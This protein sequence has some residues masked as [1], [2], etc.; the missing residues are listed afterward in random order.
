MNFCPI[1]GS[2]AIEVKTT[3]TESR[4]EHA[5][6]QCHG[7]CGN[8]WEVTTIDGGNGPDEMRIVLMTLEEVEEA[9]KKAEE[10]QD[11]V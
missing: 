1:C 4:R 5:V 7:D 6:V 11:G 10:V 9:M 8:F 2:D 3:L